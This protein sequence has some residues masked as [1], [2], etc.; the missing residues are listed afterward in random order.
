MNSTIDAKSVIDISSQCTPGTAAGVVNAK[1]KWIQAYYD[2]SSCTVRGTLYIDTE[3]EF[4]VTAIFV[5][6]Q[7]YRP[8]S[9]AYF[10]GVGRN[11][12]EVN[13]YQGR[14]ETNG[15]IV[16]ALTNH[17]LVF[18]GTFEFKV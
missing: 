7:Q 8:S 17:C 1:N 12:G 2:P 14:I 13:P 9:N 15:A 16:Q 3:T 18:S 5:L 10:A 11:T 6:P 4:G